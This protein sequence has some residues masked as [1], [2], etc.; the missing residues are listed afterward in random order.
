MRAI[1]NLLQAQ[2]KHLLDNAARTDITVAQARS[3]VAEKT[4][5]AA[6][7]RARAARLHELAE[8]ESADE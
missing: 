2:A 3:E 5:E 1:K 7:L 6:D 4:K 8:A